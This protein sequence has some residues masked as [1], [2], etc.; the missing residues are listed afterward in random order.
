MLDKD[1]KEEKIDYERKTWRGEVGLGVKSLR[2]DAKT[3][4]TIGKKN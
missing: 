2:Y 1:D 3:L 4:I